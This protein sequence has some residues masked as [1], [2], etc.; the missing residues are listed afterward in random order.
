[1]INRHQG[2][3][4]TSQLGGC[5][6]SSVLIVPMRRHSPSM[7][8]FSF[9]IAVSGVSTTVS[10][11]PN[12]EAV[13]R[14]EVSFHARSL[15]TAWSFAYVLAARLEERLEG[16]AFPCALGPPEVA[17]TGVGSYRVTFDVELVDEG[18]TDAAKT[19]METFAAG[20]LASVS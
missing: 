12:R 2:K 10:I 18:D 9:S 20:L 1:M 7:V 4:A 6:S 14:L 16:T 11:P 5:T 19:Y 15:G 13:V 8:P 3:V 17:N